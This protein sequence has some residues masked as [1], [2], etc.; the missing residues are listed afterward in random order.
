MSCKNKQIISQA[1]NSLYV[2]ERA[3]EGVILTHSYEVMLSIYYST[4][5]VA[6]SLLKLFSTPT[7]FLITQNDFMVFFSE[8][9]KKGQRDLYFWDALGW[10]GLMLLA[11]I[12][13][14]T[15]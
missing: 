8:G 1:L 10:A 7:R 14:A 13:R 15:R 11:F 6:I 12:F 3:C 2:I 4:V 9:K 5:R